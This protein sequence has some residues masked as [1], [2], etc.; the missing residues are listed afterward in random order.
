MA[1]ITLR[2]A[3]N[4]DWFARKMVPEELRAT[5]KAKFGVS[6][7]VRFREPKATP[8]WRA[9]QAFR[10]CDADITA[11]IEA[12]GVTGRPWEVSRYGQRA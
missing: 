10:E 1:P 11:R 5:H 3:R 7:E 6:Y 2:Q 4:G 9:K 12:A 8:D